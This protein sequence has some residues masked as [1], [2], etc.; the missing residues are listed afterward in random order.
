MKKRLVC[1]ILVVSLLLSGCGFFSAGIKDPVVFYYLCDSYTE[2]LC[3][4]MVS[5]EREASGHM[6]DLPYLLA[7]YVMGPVNDENVSPLPHGTRIQS[8]IADGHI[9]LELSGIPRKL[10]DVDFSLASACLTMT[11]LGITDAEDVTIRHGDQETT[12]SRS[13][14]TLYDAAGEAIPTEETK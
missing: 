10:S 8:Q 1:L 11:C 12:L 2:D 4:V 9:F 5:E 6:G 13:S 3:C 14:L 7:L